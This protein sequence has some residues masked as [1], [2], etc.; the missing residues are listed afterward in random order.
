[1]D[2]DR[3]KEVETDQMI[4]DLVDGPGVQLITDKDYRMPY[5]WDEDWPDM[6]GSDD[7]QRMESLRYHLEN[8]QFWCDDRRAFDGIASKTQLAERLMYHGGVVLKILL[9]NL[10]SNGIKLERF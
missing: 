4:D 3:A 2:V 1:M 7:P 5:N 6:I 10:E 8:A 9:E